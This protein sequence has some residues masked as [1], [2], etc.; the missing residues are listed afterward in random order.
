MPPFVQGQDWDVSH[1]AS[2][3]VTSFAGKL[4]AMASSLTLVLSSL[5]QPVVLRKK[6]PSAA[7]AKEEKAVNAVSGTIK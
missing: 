2:L 6:P 5:A 7:A 1:S 3:A 4:H